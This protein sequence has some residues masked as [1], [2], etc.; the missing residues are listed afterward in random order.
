[1][2]EMVV[3]D[4][5]PALQA[6]G[7]L[8]ATVSRVVRTAGLGES[9]VAEVVAPVV[10]RLDAQTGD[11]DRVT[12]AFLA[13]AGEARVRITAKAADREAALALIAPVVDEVV[14]RLGA[15]VVGL[16]D[17]SGAHAVARLLTRRGWSLAV[18]ESVSGGGLGSR[19]VR[20]AGASTWFRGGVIVYDTQAK[21]TLAEVDPDLLQRAGPVS[22]AVAGQLAGGVARRLEAE[23]GV[24]VVGVAGPDTQGGRSVGTVCL[25]VALPDGTVQTRELQVPG[26]SRSHVQDWA[27]NAALDLLR[28][29]LAELP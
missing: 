27:A 4:V 28:R 26:R 24:G 22:E 5:V 9:A 16:D 12:A 19:L 11:A 3:R 8:G 17:E 18:A 15:N 25:G 6:R 7:G 13:S 20:V 2:Q 29:T 10:E 21:A 1:M 14:E 23:V